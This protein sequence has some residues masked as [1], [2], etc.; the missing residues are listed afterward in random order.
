MSYADVAASGPKQSAEEV[1]ACEEEDDAVFANMCAGVSDARRCSL[2][3][4][5]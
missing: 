1:S 5:H 2:Q 3:A 4:Q